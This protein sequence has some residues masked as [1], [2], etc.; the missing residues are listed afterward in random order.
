MA[1]EIGTAMARPEK[2]NFA[3]HA[4]AASATYAHAIKPMAEAAMR[5]A[6]GLVEIETF[7]DGA[8]GGAL[9]TQLELL[10]TGAADAAFVIP[11]FTPDRFPDNFV[12]GIPGL[13]RDIKELTLAFSRL[14]HAGKLAGYDAF[15]VIGAFCTEPFTIH[16]RGKLTSLSDLKGMKLRASN[17][18]DEIML[19]QLGADA[20]VVPGDKI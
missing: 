6:A 5:E 15:F 4:S 12:F 14:V 16:A 20:W 17:N 13:F 2:L 3:F 1:G 7:T 19:K 11:G 8:L 18:A 9:T 10:E